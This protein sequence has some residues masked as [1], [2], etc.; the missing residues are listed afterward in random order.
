MRSF[1]VA[2]VIL[3]VWFGQAFADLRVYFS[4]GDAP[5]EALVSLINNARHEVWV[6]AYAFTD[7]EIS[8]AL[9]KARARGVEVLVVMDYAFNRSSKYSVAKELADH[10]VPVFFDR[11][12]PTAHNKV[13]IFDKK[14]V[15]TGS[16]NYTTTAHRNSE[17]LLIISEDQ[18]VVRAYISNFN[19]HK[20]HSK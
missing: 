14:V 20:S 9:E 7:K 13:M 19:F 2:I 17:N 1:R 6:L 15:A 18:K 3:L 16:Y 12:H 8:Q 10:N 4:P 5:S 11:E